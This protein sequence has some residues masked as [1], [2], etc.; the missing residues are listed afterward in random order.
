M[1]RHGLVLQPEHVFRSQPGEA[2]GYEVARQIC[3]L[4]P[5]PTAI[6]L[7]DES[8]ALGLYRGLIEQGVIPGR[9]I[10]VIGRDSLA[11]R[12]LA[13]TMTRFGQN[14]RDLG[15][16]LA[17]ALLATMPAYAEIYDMGTVRK[18]WPMELTEGESD[19][20]RL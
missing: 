20:F 19:G 16:G 8:L 1:A 6:V 13:P 18:V 3:R 2:G 10:A 12:F 4:S 17:E 7:S 15:I 11:V 5:R 14:L 9:D